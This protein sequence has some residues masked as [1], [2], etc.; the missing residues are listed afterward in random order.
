MNEDTG[1]ASSSKGPVYFLLAAL[2]LGVFLMGKMV[3]EVYNQLP[4]REILAEALK[5]TDLRERLIRLSVDGVELRCV[6]GSKKVEGTFQFERLEGRKPVTVQGDTACTEPGLMLE[7][8]RGWKTEW[9]RAR[10]NYT[11]ELI[12][13]EITRLAEKA[14]LK[15]NTGN[16]DNPELAL[17]LQQE[18]GKPTEL[19]SVDEVLFLC[20]KA[21]APYRA[22]A[23]YSYSRSSSETEL[24]TRCELDHQNFEVSITKH[25][26]SEVFFKLHEYNHMPAPQV[27]AVYQE[28]VGASGKKSSF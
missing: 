24:Q 19:K 20:D 4:S 18:F 7:W 2:L 14:G 26:R 12:G 28:F 10:E 5:E 23:R 16:R 17:E 9:V 22:I 21:G 6:R 27:K 15:P 11:A 13:P 1:V 25:E 3:W 8:G